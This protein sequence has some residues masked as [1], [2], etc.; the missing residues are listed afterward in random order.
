M[1]FEMQI[2]LLFLTGIAHRIFPAAFFVINYH[3]SGNKFPILHAGT[4][5]Q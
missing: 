5:R 4:L 1:R 3:L 2:I